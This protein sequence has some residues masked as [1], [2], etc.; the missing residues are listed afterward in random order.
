[1]TKK[2]D[3]SRW[4]LWPK[5]AGRLDQVDSCQACLADIFEFIDMGLLIVPF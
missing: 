5:Q 2:L 4:Y 1:V 3:L